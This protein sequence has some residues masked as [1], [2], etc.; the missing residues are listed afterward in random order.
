MKRSLISI[1]IILAIS[2]SL[3]VA[4]SGIKEDFKP[5]SSNQPGKE[6]PMVNSEGR[7][8]AQISAPDAKYVQLD[9]EIGRAHV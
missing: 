9:I 6:Y 7:V 3:S 8:R 2:A 4:Q 5:A 1:L